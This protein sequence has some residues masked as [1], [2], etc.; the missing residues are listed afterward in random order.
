[1]AYTKRNKNRKTLRKK[2]GGMWPFGNTNQ[3]QPSQPPQQ[4]N[5]NVLINDRITTDP[6]NNNSK[7]KEIGIIHTTEAVGINFV[8]GFVTNISNTFGLKGVDVSRYD[9]ARNNI[10][11]KLL[12]LISPKQ[13]ICNLRMEI[14][15]TP[16]S[17]YIH[18]YGT[19]LELLEKPIDNPRP[20][21]ELRPI[22]NNQ[23]KVNQ[24][25]P[26]DNN[27]MIETNQPKDPRPINNIDT[28]IMNRL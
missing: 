21:E 27:E 26:I 18:A 10:I 5:S 25:K 23:M 12:G 19:L 17:I 4:N 1:M 11:K 15:N 2:R 9:V 3:G 28:N 20:I 7:Y 16:Q 22:E 8:R 24:P 13:K 14:D 6:N